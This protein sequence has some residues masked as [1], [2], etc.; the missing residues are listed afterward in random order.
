MTTAPDATT[1]GTFRGRLH[2][3]HLR[4]RYWEVLTDFTFIDPLDNTYTVPAGFVTDGASVPR[5]IWWLYPPLG[6]AYDEAAAIHDY[7]Y[8]HAEYFTGDDHG[9]LSRGQADQVMRWAMEAKH[10]RGT[11]V[12]TIY[13][14]L[15]LGGWIAWRRHRKARAKELAQQ[16]MAAGSRDTMDS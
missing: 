2:L 14:S 7:L 5:A 6:G 12:V 13:R 16:V 4:G 9:H 8:A 11:A 10:L 1:Q 15:R 3:A